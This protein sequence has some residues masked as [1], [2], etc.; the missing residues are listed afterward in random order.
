MR[1]EAVDFT[2]ASTAFRAGFGQRPDRH[3]KRQMA[4]TNRRT[5]VAKP[6]RTII[7]A[8]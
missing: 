3:P 6:D 4:S 2:R 8:E 1:P 5:A 7:A